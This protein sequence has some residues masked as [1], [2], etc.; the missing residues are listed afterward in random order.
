MD[1]PALALGPLSRTLVSRDPDSRGHA[2]LRPGHEPELRIEHR[3]ALIYTLAKAAELEHLIICQYLFAAFSLKRDASEGIPG[4]M[5]QTVRGWARSLMHIAEQEMLHLAL[6]QNLLTAVGASPHLSRPNFPVPPRAFPARIQIALLPFG[7][8]ALRHFAFL[9]RPEFGAEGAEVEDV[10]MFAALAQA[11]ALPDV[12]EDQIGP[13]VADFETISHLYRSIED[14]LGRLAERMG[15]ERLFIGPVSAQAT[16]EHFRFPEL[17]A[18]TNLESARAAIETIVEQGE[19]ARGEWRSSH[20][21]QILNVLDQL[22]AAKAADPDFDPT[23]PILAAHVR[24]PESGVSVPLISARFTVR[25]TDLLNASYEVALQLLARYFNHTDESDA[26][27]ETL[28][29]AAVYLMEEVISPL[30][31]LITRLPIGSDYPGKNAGPTFELF[32]DADWLLPHRDAAWQLI[33]ERVGE[34]AAFAVACRNECPPGFTQELVAVA[35]KLR[36]LA[37]RF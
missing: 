37:D 21:G 15:E 14:G 19:G 31:E 18:V 25:A 4:P 29:H 8:E 11:Q 30:G 16:G 23:R 27:L 22:V 12:S 7:E 5:V 13:I 1:K 2:G 28:A 3:Q 32:Y 20:F 10:E 26:Q 34:L 35:D 9:E 24:P 17:V 36:E 33:G 6:V